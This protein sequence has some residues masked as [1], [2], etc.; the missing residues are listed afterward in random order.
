MGIIV[1][2]EGYFHNWIMTMHL[3][4]MAQVSKHNPNPLC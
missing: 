2:S 3:A 1:R 4:E